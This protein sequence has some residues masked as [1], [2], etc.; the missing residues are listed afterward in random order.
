MYYLCKLWRDPSFQR[1]GLV[2]SPLV[3]FLP[4]QFCLFSRLGVEP[5][6]ALIFLR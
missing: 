5:M 6:M 2:Q 1:S 3:S 4:P